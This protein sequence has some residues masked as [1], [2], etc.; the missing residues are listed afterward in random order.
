MQ[1]SQVAEQKMH[2]LA[3]P[4]QDKKIALDFLCRYFSNRLEKIIE[5]SE[6]ERLNDD[7]YLYMAG[8]SF[9]HDG[10]ERLRV[11]FTTTEEVQAGYQIENFEFID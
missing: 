4:Q 5:S 2:G 10:S 3:G 7:H 6:T 8:P 9:K 11:L 1:F